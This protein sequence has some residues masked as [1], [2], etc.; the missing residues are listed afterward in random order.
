[1]GAALALPGISRLKL[2]IGRGSTVA[3]MTQRGEGVALMRAEM[4]GDQIVEAEWT[5]PRHPFA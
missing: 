2:G 4:P 3:I 1:M 5:S